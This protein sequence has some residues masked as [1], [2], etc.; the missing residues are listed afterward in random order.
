MRSLIFTTIAV[1]CCVFLAERPCCAASPSSKE[2]E[3]LHNELLKDK[4][5]KDADGKMAV[6]DTRLLLEFEAEKAGQGYFT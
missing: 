1:F 2:A 3:A 5:Y 4:S 6:A